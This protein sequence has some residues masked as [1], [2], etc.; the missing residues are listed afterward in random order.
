M[1]ESVVLRR[2]FESAGCPGVPVV[3]N[4]CA[5]YTLHTRLRVREHPAFPTPLGRKD[6]CMTRA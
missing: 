4:S 3:T 2:P 1:S 6:S 5:F